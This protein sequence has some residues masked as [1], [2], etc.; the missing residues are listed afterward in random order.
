M[1]ANDALLT[2]RRVSIEYANIGIRAVDNVSCD[3][4][5]NEVLGLVGESGSGK[6]TLGMAILGGLP[7]SAR[8]VDGEIQFEGHDLARLSNQERRK[9]RWNSISYVPQG[10]MSALNPVLSIRSQFLDIFRDHCERSDASIHRKKIEDLVA[11]VRLTSDC[12]DKYPHELSGGMRQ[13]I[14]IA[15]AI[16]L[17]PKLIIADEPTSALDVISQKNVLQMLSSARRELG[18]SMIL[19]GHD[20]AIQ[21]QIAD[22][23]GIMFAGQLVEIGPVANIFSSP[24]HPYTRRLLA[25]VPSIRHRVGLK[26]NESDNDDFLTKIMVGAENTLVE[27]TRGHFAMITKVAVPKARQ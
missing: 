15:M 22:R 1:T 24:V 11:K 5:K 10:A 16:A 20:L 17:D 23:L 25:A 8:I 14:C 18:A 13:R 3:V 21:A 26:S 7:R 9:L 6:T 19:I 12:L 27:V 4:K 2:V